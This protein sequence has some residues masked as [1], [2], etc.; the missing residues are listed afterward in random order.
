MKPFDKCEADEFLWLQA[1]RYSR[2]TRKQKTR[3]N[4]LV[5]RRNAWKMA[6]YGG[7]VEYYEDGDEGDGDGDDDGS[8]VTIPRDLVQRD[9]FAAEEA[10][11]EGGGL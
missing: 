10:T 11:A 3:W 8:V 7:R 5:G 2:L 1:R 4:E 9:L 6:E